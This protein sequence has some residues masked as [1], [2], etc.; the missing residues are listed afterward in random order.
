M[1]V[2][3]KSVRKGSLCDRKGVKSAWKLLSIDGEEISDVLDYQFHIKTEKPVL[4]FR[5]EKGKTRSIRMKTGGDD[6]IG[7]EF[8]TYLMDREHGCANKCIFC[9]VDQ[10]PPGM[11]ETLY[12]K[13]DDSRL[14][15]LFGNYITLTNLS[16][17]DIDRIIKMHISPVNVSVH[18]MNPELRVRM[19]KNRFAGESLSAL[20]E[21]AEAGITLN[22]QLVLCP[23]INDGAELEYSLNELGKLFPAVQ[24]IA[25]VPVG[26]TKHRE[27]LYRLKEYDR[28]A[29]LEVV[30]TVDSFGDAFFE[31]HGTRLA[32][33]SDEFYL[34][35]QLPLPDEG[36]YEDYPQ[37]ENGVGLCRS[38]ESEFSAA[39]RDAEPSFERGKISL[40]TGSLA[41]PMMRSIADSARSCFPNTEYEVFEIKNDFFGESVT[42]AGL[43]TGGDLIAQLSGKALGEKLLIP[44]VMLKRDED[45][46]LDDVTLS[47]AEEALGVPIRPVPNDGYELFEAMH[48]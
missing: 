1:A 28:Q 38:L 3:I 23:G 16:R 27:G 30:K 15:F 41:A 4:V 2:D 17:R 13:D 18:T 25:C 43:I 22:T 14:S 37:L 40:A 33:C 42:V 44:S 20:K 48:L 39:A 46:F 36:Y 6:D 24:S 34:L 7:L 21:F 32:Y 31:K 35:A 12:F 29:A 45:V 8:E 11:R 10:M 5:T 9:F 26:L 47:E 19:M